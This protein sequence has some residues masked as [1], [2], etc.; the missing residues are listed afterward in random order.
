MIAI[1]VEPE[2]RYLAR[3]LS[4]WGPKGEPNAPITAG[5]EVGDFLMQLIRSC[6]CS[7]GLLWNVR[8]LNWIRIPVAGEDVVMLHSGLL[9]PADCAWI[10]LRWRYVACR[11]LTTHQFWIGNSDLSRRFG[12]MV[13]PCWS[14]SWGGVQ[15][16]EEEPHFDVV[17]LLI[18]GYMLEELTTFRLLCPTMLI[19]RA[20]LFGSH[21]GLTRV[22]K[23]WSLG[24]RLPRT[25]PLKSWGLEVTWNRSSFCWRLHIS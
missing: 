1:G 10:T 8:V 13:G 4:R 24:W 17:D 14:P 12:P 20:S 23:Y 7:A 2:Y 3:P 25:W 15:F 11:S 9:C 21:Q 22:I 6:S 19:L 5:S 16:D 18:V